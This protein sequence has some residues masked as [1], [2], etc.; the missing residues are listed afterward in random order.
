MDISGKAFFGLGVFLIGAAFLPSQPRDLLLAGVKGAVQGFTEHIAGSTSREEDR[1]AGAETHWIYAERSGTRAALEDH[2]AQ[3]GHCRFVGLAKDAVAKLNA[4]ARPKPGE[5][6]GGYVPGAP[7]TPAECI[8]RGGTDT[9]RGC[10]GYQS[11]GDGKRS[12]TVPLDDSRCL[13]AQSGTVAKVKPAANA[14]RVR[15]P[16]TGMCSWYVPD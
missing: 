9:G 2:I 5:P 15:N 16:D 3:F 7:T 13:T 6:G 11:T 4:P 14:I 8:A 12:S 10:S 1:C